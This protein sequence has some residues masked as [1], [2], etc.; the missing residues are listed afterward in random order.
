MPI[1]SHLEKLINYKK[2]Y[3]HIVQS[4]LL[5]K[6]AILETPFDYSEIVSYS[7]TVS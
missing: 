2:A 1:V 7:S 5:N 6:D 4:Q 3:M